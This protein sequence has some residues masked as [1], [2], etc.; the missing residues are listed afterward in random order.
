MQQVCEVQGELPSK[1]VSCFF[2]LTPV[3]TGED[4]ISRY[5]RSQDAEAADLFAWE[6]PRIDAYTFQKGMLCKGA[7]WQQE[8]PIG[9][10]H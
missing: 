6:L 8:I 10:H 2:I 3:L 4:I 5:Y 1:E 9:H 7:C